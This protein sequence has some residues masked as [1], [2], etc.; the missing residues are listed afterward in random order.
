[1]P[2]APDPF[3]I[4]HE[5]HAEMRPVMV[6]NVPHCASCSGEFIEILDPT[7]NPDPLYE[8]P[9][10]PPIRPP[11]MNPINDPANPRRAEGGRT[12]DPQAGIGGLFDL[13]AG[14]PQEAINRNRTASPGVQ[15]NGNVGTAGGGGRTWRFDF[16]GGGHGSMTFGATGGTGFGM[17]GGGTLGGGGGDNDAGLDAFFPGFA[18]PPR[19]GNRN[20]TAGEAMNPQDLVSWLIPVLTGEILLRLLVWLS[21][22]MSMMH[23]EGGA[24]RAFG[25]AGTA[26]LGDYVMT[27]HGFDDILERLM[28]AAGPQ[29]P[30]PASEVVIEGLPRLTLDEKRLKESQFKDCPVCKDDF[31][32][33]EEVIQ[34]PCRHIFH[35]DCI[36]PWL[37]VNGSCPVCRF[38]LVPDEANRQSNTTG[39]TSTSNGSSEGGIAAGVSGFIRGLF[40]GATTNTNETSNPNNTNPP[41]PTTTTSL[42]PP[43]TTTNNSNPSMP[44]SNDRNATAGPSSPSRPTSRN[45]DQRN[46]ASPIRTT[47][48]SSTPIP[49][50]GAGEERPSATYS[51]AIPDDYRERHQRRERELDAQRERERDARSRGGGQPDDFG[52]DDLD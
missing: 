20:T 52:Y 51:N 25:P 6:D 22:L 7:I 33:G 9:P 2:P 18:A 46:S 38:S 10:P 27:D 40:G 4:C 31:A 21:V 16:P 44:T 29:G 12:H 43:S 35:P 17:F 13:F 24:A 50:S 32:V 42:N 5:C 28:S 30:V 26:N 36:Q 48:S 49:S 47:E 45:R 23:E 14:P 41:P 39:G 37:R 8:L 11:S 3:W 1:M 19:P 15:G 34:V